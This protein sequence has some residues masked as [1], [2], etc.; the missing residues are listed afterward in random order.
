MSTSLFLKKKFCVK[1]I[2][3]SETASQ[4][5]LRVMRT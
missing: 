3:S 1:I 5:G 2:Q 4:K